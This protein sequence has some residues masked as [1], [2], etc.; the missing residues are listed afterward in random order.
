M[1]VAYYDYFFGYE[2]VMGVEESLTT[3]TPHHPHRKR[4]TAR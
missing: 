4:V 1:G 2:S 3:T